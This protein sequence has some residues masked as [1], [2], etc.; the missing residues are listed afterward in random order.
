MELPIC[1]NCGCQFKKASNSQK[2]C[3]DCFLIN[4]KD[5]A[6]KYMK[7]YRINNPEK[8][9]SYVRK[10]YK[11]Y[12]EKLRPYYSLLQREYY[13]NHLEESR[14]KGRERQKKSREKLA[15]PYVKKLIS[16]TENPTPEMIEQKRLSL[17]IIRKIKQIQTQLK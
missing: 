7:E 14:N 3:S 11:K 8:F 13:K 6:K 12:N 16:V 5:V 9:S 2:F 15:D 4:R 10:Y 17:K 1:K